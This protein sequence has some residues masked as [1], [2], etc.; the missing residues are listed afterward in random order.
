MG[1][2]PNYLADFS[3]SPPT[4]KNPKVTGHAQNSS[5]R[6]FFKEV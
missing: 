6:D 5:K 4:K 3:Y 1:F 2:F